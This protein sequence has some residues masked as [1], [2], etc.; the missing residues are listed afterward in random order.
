[1]KAAILPELSPSSKWKGGK[2]RNSAAKTRDLASSRLCLQFPL[3][4]S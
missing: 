2:L 4:R 1:M 3:I